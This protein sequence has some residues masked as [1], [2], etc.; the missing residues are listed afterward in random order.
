[1]NI[2]TLLAKTILNIQS[3]SLFLYFIEQYIQSTFT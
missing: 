2:L 3:I 1:M